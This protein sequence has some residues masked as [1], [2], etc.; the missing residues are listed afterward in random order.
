MSEV[1]N[2]DVFYT[3]Q[4]YVLEVSGDESIVKPIE[5][6]SDAEVQLSKVKPNLKK[7]FWSTGEVTSRFCQV[8]G[9]QGPYPGG[10]LSEFAIMVKAAGF[11]FE[12]P[13]TKWEAVKG[14]KEGVIYTLK[15]TVSVALEKNI[16]KSVRDLAVLIV[17][18]KEW[19]NAVG[20]LEKGIDFCDTKTHEICIRFTSEIRAYFTVTPV[21]VEKEADINVDEITV[22]KVQLEEEG[23]T[24]TPSNEPT[25]DDTTEEEQ[26]P[27][28]EP[29]DPVDPETGA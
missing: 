27:K 2:N 5:L 26:G 17:D 29:L 8:Y 13:V 20:T 14:E 18:G 1:N 28:E 21:V 9:V 19:S 24:E 23:T 16:P 22:D 3:E 11:P 25:G 12:G 15:G 6:S 4:G 7:V 10:Y